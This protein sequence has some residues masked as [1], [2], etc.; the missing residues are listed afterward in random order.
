MNSATEKY[1]AGL[2]WRRN[3]IW[4]EEPAIEP[5]YAGRRSTTGDPGRALIRKVMTGTSAT[6]SFTI[7]KSAIPVSVRTSPDI[8]TAIACVS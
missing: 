1:L 2:R 3:A 7:K 5:P 4:D 8:S 6:P